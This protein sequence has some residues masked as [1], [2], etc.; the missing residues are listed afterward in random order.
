MPWQVYGNDDLDFRSPEHGVLTSYLSDPHCHGKDNIGHEDSTCRPTVNL[1][2]NEPA[3]S[4]F[5]V[6]RMVGHKQTKRTDQTVLQ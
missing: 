5:I 1:R 2:S 4:F 3:C 6:R